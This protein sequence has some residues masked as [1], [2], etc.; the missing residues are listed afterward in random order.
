MCKIEEIVEDVY[1]DMCLDELIASEPYQIRLRKEFDTASWCYKG[2]MHYIFIGDK[3]LETLISKG[4]EAEYLSSFLH[5]EVSHSLYTERDLVHVS[6][7]LKSYKIPFS[8]FNFA[9]DARIED[10]MRKKS[11]RKFNWSILE[12]TFK[13]VSP[14]DELFYIIQ[15][16]GDC[17]LEAS[18]SSDKVATFHR[19]F[20]EAKTS[21]DVI[22]LLVE[23]MKEFPDTQEETED[24]KDKL[25]DSDKSEDDDRSGDSRGES[26]E[27][28]PSRNSLE[29]LLNSIKLLEDNEAFEDAMK[30]SRAL[31][32]GED[33]DEEVESEIESGAI[34]SSVPVLECSNAKVSFPDSLEWD[35]LEAVEQAEKF[36]SIFVSK[37]GHIKTKRSSKHINKK[38]FRIGSTTNKYFR[39]KENERI[40][41]KKVTLILDCSGS[42]QMTMKNMRIVIGTFNE[43]AKEGYVSGNIIL[44]GVRSRRAIYETFTLPVEDSVIG[45]FRAFYE[46]EGIESGIKNNISLVKESDYVFVLTDGDIYDEPI[47]KEE[48]HIHGIY[49]IG[50]YIGNPDRC[51]LNKWFDKGIALERVQDCIDEIA[52]YIGE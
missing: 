47:Q 52:S 3:V 21:Y 6:K 17:A 35:T 22:E 44:T 13:P 36:K 40:T 43:L 7:V 24:L 49:T 34:C 2:G 39:R 25:G 1:L 37:K 18:E 42:M 19:Y 29:D 10:L 15:H 50:I 23:W 14:I 38:A 41:P 9:E 26:G 5:H 32:G 31:V 30:S 4:D 51:N 48:Y 12:A 45:T 16:D 20:C 28:K 27:P 8:L 11:S 33:Q 46:A